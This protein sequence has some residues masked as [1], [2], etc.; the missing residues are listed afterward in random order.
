[1]SDNPLL[2]IG[3]S[4]LDDLSVVNFENNRNKQGMSKDCTEELSQIIKLSS[5]P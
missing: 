1:M 3:Y 5:A 4:P 2:F